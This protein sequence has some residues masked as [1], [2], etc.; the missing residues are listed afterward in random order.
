MLLI[1]D[2]SECWHGFFLAGLPLAA[3]V[4]ITLFI[5]PPLQNE[6]SGLKIHARI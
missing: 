2:L 1:V 4:T 5:L 3:P 6:Q